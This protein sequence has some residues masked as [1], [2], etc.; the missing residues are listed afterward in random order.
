[1]SSEEL[2]EVKSIRERL[3]KGEITQT[4]AQVLVDELRKR[5]ESTMTPGRAVD[6]LVLGKTGSVEIEWRS[7]DGK[8]GKATLDKGAFE[9]PA[10]EL[11]GDVVT[12]RFFKGA[13]EKL[14]A[15]KLPRNVVIDLRQ[16]TIGDFEVMRRCLEIV[17]QNRAYGRIDNEQ[18]G[19][20]RPVEIT[21]S[22][23]PS[24]N[25]EIVADGT[26]WGAAA[27]FASALVK[28]GSASMPTG[29]VANDLPWIELME[30]PDGS[31]Y[32]L[33]TGTFVPRSAK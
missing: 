9:L 13:P 12:L 10:V 31:G 14:S 25:I 7:P 3:A 17:G 8:S 16:S 32:T 15:L 1:V 33:R 19:K 23:A 22:S 11:N 21:N 4:G 20:A 2:S 30:L 28:T 27:V 29:N 26:T 6:Q 18:A 24:R 5:F